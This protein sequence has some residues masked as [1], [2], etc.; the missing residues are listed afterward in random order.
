MSR[1]DEIIKWLLNGDVSIQ[2]YVHKDLLSSDSMAQQKLQ[3]RIER[4]G[5]GA[6]LLSQRQGN[7]HWGRGFYVPKWTS[8]HYTLL[9]LRN[10]G[11]PRENEQARSSIKMIFNGAIGRDGGIDYSK[12]LKRQQSDVCIDGM[13]LNFASYFQQVTPQLL[14]IIDLLLSVQM[15]DGGWNCEHIHGATHSSLH[16]TV[17]VLEGLLEYKQT[18]VNYRKKEVEKAEKEGV[19]FILEHQLYKSHRTGDT[20]DKKMLMLSYPS[21]WRYD[22]LRVLDYFQL[23]EIKYDDRMNSAIEVLFKKQRKDGKWPLQMKHPGRVHFD[24]EKA[25]QASRWNTLRALRVLRHYETSRTYS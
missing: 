4:G 17:S 20:I 7:G 18:G 6:Q 12:H 25:G 10:I 1:E 23:A 22:I 16:T 21:R 13:V 5:W 11:L 15:K 24:M 9:D 2:Y 3:E 14:R 19:E 8:T